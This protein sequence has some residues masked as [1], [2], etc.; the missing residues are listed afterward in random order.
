MG[1]PLLSDSVVSKEDLQ[2]IAN[3][4]RKG[5]EVKMWMNRDGVKIVA[6]KR[7]V[8]IIKSPRQN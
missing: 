3:A 2:E 6:E 4:L 1:Q 7:K 5:Y 8:E